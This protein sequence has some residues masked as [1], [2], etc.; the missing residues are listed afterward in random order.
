V[1]LHY[2]L[3]GPEHAPAILVL[4]GA[5][6]N[7]HEPKLALAEAFADYRV[8]WLDRPG[9]GW[10]ERPQEGG[11]WTPEREAALIVEM[12]AAL[13]IDE[14]A[15]VGHS[16]GAA[17][18]M[19]LMMDHP[20]RV[21]GG[22]LIAPALRAHVG[23]AAFYNHV[24]GWPLVGTLLT[25]I[26]VPTLGPGA[27]ESGSAS[28]FHPVEPPENYVEDVRLRLILRPE[29]W[30]ANAADM[31]RVNIS[32]EEQET[33]YSEITQPVII[34]A[35]DGD[36]VVYT[37]RHSV[38]VAEVLPQGELRLIEGEGHNPH[39]RHAGDVAQALADVIARSP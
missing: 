38:P 2:H 16:W 15:V 26:V 5:S 1:D 24:T 10:S 22:V 11:D 23:E 30:R 19:R 29:T 14:V 7:L 9:L 17:I 8:L 35:S 31:A 33:R 6:G 39:H 3:T 20:D 4:H 37:N 32:L 18:S 13:D 27:L 21:R 34:V 28:A 36:T 12:L 25:R